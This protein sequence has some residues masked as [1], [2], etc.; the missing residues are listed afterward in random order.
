MIVTIIQALLV[1]F[2]L[3]IFIKILDYIRRLK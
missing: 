2:E 1:L 3:I